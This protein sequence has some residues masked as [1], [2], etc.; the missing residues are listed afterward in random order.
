MSAAAIWLVSRAPDEGALCAS[1]AAAGTTSALP[2]S[3][4]LTSLF[5][6]SIS[7]EKPREYASISFDFSSPANRARRWDGHS[8]RPH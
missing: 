8:C 7:P 1:A 5:L 6:V 4:C 3:T 2:D